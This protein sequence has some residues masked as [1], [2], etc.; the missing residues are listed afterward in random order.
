MKKLAVVFVT[1]QLLVSEAVWAAPPLPAGWHSAEWWDLGGR[2]RSDVVADLKGDG[3]VGIATVAIRDDRE[4]IGILVWY[5]NQQGSGKWT[6]LHEQ[7]IPSSMANFALDAQPIDDNSTRSA[8]HYCMAAREC[9]VFAWD[10]KSNSFKRSVE[11]RKAVVKSK[12]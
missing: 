12:G 4:I 9:M 7:K 6:V 5:G 8:V 3:A 1:L 11:A 2:D 10:E